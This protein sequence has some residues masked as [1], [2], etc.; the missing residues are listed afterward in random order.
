MK[1]TTARQAMFTSLR[2][3]IRKVWHQLQ[4]EEF[5]VARCTVALL[6]YGTF[7]LEIPCR[8]VTKSQPCPKNMVNRKFRASAPN[9]L[10]VSDFTYVST[11]ARQQ[12]LHV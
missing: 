4:R 7:P 12:C 5:K 1:S 6:P 9:M 2:G 10:W 3:G 8:A 11:I